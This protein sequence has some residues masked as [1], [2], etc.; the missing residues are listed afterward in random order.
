MGSRVVFE[1]YLSEYKGYNIGGVIEQNKQKIID[2]CANDAHLMICNK[3]AHG[4]FLVPLAIGFSTPVN[5]I[6]EDGYIR[7]MRNEKGND[8][9]NQYEQWK[10][11]YQTTNI[12]KPKPIKFSS[13]QSECSICL[14]KYKPGDELAELD[15]KHRLHQKCKTRWQMQNMPTDK[16]ELIR[17]LVYEKQVVFKC[18]LCRNMN[19]AE[20]NVVQ[21]N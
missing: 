13:D 7:I 16:S 15:C 21:E 3:F 12:V 2:T 14:E 8:L 19:H 18:P 4:S 11:I 6:C 1:I 5:D 10:K 17:L 20:P 9:L